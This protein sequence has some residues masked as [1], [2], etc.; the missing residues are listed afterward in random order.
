MAKSL[1]SLATY[2]V[3][4]QNHSAPTF[5]FGY[6]NDV[7]IYFSV[8]TAVFSWVA[9]L[10]D[11]ALALASHPDTSTRI[12]SASLSDSL[13]WWMTDSVVVRCNF[14][15]DGKI[16]SLGQNLIFW[17]GNGHFV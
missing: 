16:H 9:R 8:V 13:M 17:L 5:V 2:I 6:N 10:E 12:Y 7:G 14:L 3:G 1:K 15:C 11:D 4:I